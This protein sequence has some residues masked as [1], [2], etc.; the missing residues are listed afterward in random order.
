VNADTG[1]VS[2]GS[3]SAVIF[4]G[5]DTQFT[6]VYGIKTYKQF[7]NTLEDNI[8]HNGA[9]N[10]LISDRNQV[11]ISYLIVDI[12]RNLCIV[13]QQSDPHQQQ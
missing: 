13:S 8:I 7:V 11:I 6:D 2:D 1:A 10:K 3:T 5:V 12:L 4:V 9:P